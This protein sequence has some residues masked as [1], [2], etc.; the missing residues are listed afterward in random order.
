VDGPRAIPATLLILVGGVALMVFL[1]GDALIQLITASTILPV[2]VYGAT[3]VLY[4]AVRKRLEAREGAFSLGRF[5]LPVAILALAWLVIALVVLVAPHEARTPV[6][7]VL[8]LIVAGAA[9]F[10]LMLAFNREAL[11]VE[12]AE[13]AAEASAA[14][15]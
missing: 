9:F 15:A 14:N 11:E 6:L 7:I 8:G 2:V 13:P 4:L 12:P 3:V 1:P 5:D 10:G